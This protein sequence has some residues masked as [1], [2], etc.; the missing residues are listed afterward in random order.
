MVLGYRSANFSV[1]NFHD[2][3]SLWL[4]MVGFFAAIST[5][6]LSDVG[7]YLPPAI[8]IHYGRAV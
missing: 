2:P 4:V 3:E 8:L 6:L 5:C 7:E 1:T